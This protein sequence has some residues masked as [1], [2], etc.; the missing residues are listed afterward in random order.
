M[1]VFCTGA[2]G[3]IG[4]NFVNALIERNYQALNFDIKAPLDERQRP[5]WIEGDILDIAHLKAEIRGTC[6]E[7]VVHLAARTDTPP[8]G[9]LRDYRV[10]TE[11]SA[12]VLAS[13]KASENVKRSVFVST[14]YVC[15]AGYEPSN[16]EDFAPYTT[17][18]ESKAIMER[19]TREADLKSTWTI[20]RPTNIWGPWHYRYRDELWSYIERR[21]YVHPGFAP[22]IRSYGYV[23]NVTDQLVRI[24]EI[25][26]EVVHKRVFYV[27]DAPIDSLEWLN[28]WSQELTGRPIRV[29]PR[30]VVRTMALCGE[31]L[32]LIGLPT[33]ITSLRY[34]SMTRNYAPSLAKTISVFGKPPYNLEDGVRQT[35]EWI[36][37][38]RRKP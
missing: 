31:L 26:P 1:R 8:V 38:S 34:R 12:N 27:G 25:E 18:G 14:Q 4:T 35:L 23:G 10:N 22:I 36:R 28:V 9:T 6:A 5:Y 21:L 2:S 3:F 19:L 15:R 37:W 24:L 11:G 17:Y 20:V 30:S 29:V 16:D 32:Q 7:C 13:V 33:P